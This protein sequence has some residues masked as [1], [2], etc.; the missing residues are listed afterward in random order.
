MLTRSAD[1]SELAKKLGADEV[2]LTGDHAG[3]ALAAAGGADIILNTG[4]SSKIASQAMEGLRPEGRLV[5]MGVDETADLLQISPLL[6]ISKQL[7]VLGSKQDER[8]D[9]VDIL[10][11]AADGKI[12]PMIETYSLNNINHALERLMKG[13]VRYRA[14]ITHGD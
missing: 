9:L 11:M 8:S 2:V 1:K 14:V 6:L 4:N 3:K 5:G 10:L 12:K 13:Q 7:Q